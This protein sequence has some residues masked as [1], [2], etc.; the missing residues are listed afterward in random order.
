MVRSPI[1][2]F[3]KRCLAPSHNKN[4]T[5]NIIKIYETHDIEMWELIEIGFLP[6]EMITNEMRV[7]I[8]PNNIMVMKLRKNCFFLT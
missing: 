3:S 7:P 6:N 5:G 8:A 1:F 4:K 2:I